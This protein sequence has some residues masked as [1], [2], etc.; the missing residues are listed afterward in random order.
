MK[1]KTA[2]VLLGLLLG[3]SICHPKGTSDGQKPLR[4]A[5]IEKKFGVRYIDTALGQDPITHVSVKAWTFYLPDAKFFMQSI[6]FMVPVGASD[7]QVKWAMYS[8][9]FCSGWYIGLK[10]YLESA[11]TQELH[12]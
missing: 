8:A 9:E 12:Q 4:V 7:E 10:K 2:L 11:D 3:V 6:G 5:E 1:V